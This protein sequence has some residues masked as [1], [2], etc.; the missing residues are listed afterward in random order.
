MLRA[1]GT[2][3][4]AVAG[5]R[6]GKRQLSAS[7]DLSKQLEDQLQG[8]ATSE[9]LL[10]QVSGHFLLVRQCSNCIPILPFIPSVYVNIDYSPQ[11]IGSCSLEKSGDDVYTMVA[12]DVDNV[13][14]VMSGY[15]WTSVGTVTTS[16]FVTYLLPE[17]YGGVLNDVAINLGD[18]DAIITTTLTG[19]ERY[20][21]KNDNTTRY[22]YQIPQSL[23][24]DKLL[25]GEPSAPVYYQ[26]CKIMTDHGV[27]F[28]GRHSGYVSFGVAGAMPRDSQQK[29]GG[30]VITDASSQT[31]ISDPATAGSALRQ[32]SA[33][34]QQL[35]SD[36]SV[37]QSSQVKELNSY[38]NFM[39]EH[40]NPEGERVSAGDWVN[41]VAVALNGVATLVQQC[42]DGCDSS[43]WVNTVG[44]TL[45]AVAFVVG[46]AFPPAGVAVAVVGAVMQIVSIFLDNEGPSGPPTPFSQ[47]PTLSLSQIQDAVDKS[48][49][50]YSTGVDISQFHGMSTFATLDVDQTAR[51][52]SE[53]SHIRSTKGDAAQGLI[54]TQIQRWHEV[55]LATWSSYQTSIYQVFT[56]YDDKMGVGANSLRKNLKTWM[57]TC[58]DKCLLTQENPTLVIAGNREMSEC[59]DKTTDASGVFEQLKQLSSALMSLAFKLSTLQWSIVAIYQQATDCGGTNITEYSCPYKHMV[60]SIDNK[61][62]KVNQYAFYVKEALEMMKNDCGHV[63]WP[64]SQRC[65]REKDF[66][67]YGNVIIIPPQTVDATINQVASN[68]LLTYLGA[69][70]DMLYDGHRCQYYYDR[71]HG[72]NGYGELGVYGIRFPPYPYP[73]GKLLYARYGACD[74]L[75]DQVIR[76]NPFMMPQGRANIYGVPSFCIQDKTCKNEISYDQVWGFSLDR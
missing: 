26:Q 13:M 28:K 63:A 3:R 22:E 30:V 39:K 53:L 7:D 48:I 49:S 34:L 47:I 40:F 24:L 14:Y 15:P 33:D 35:S 50:S 2:R 67:N 73:D 9:K 61:V 10:M 37:V 66:C 74:W 45:T 68:G 62:S 38:G 71:W 59:H 42:A 8:V 36:A 65:N 58:E 46:A 52:I 18:G 11:V 6:S 31:I 16:Y 1:H 75:E 41:G 64:F 60:E 76:N 29:N 5:K 23:E 54:D 32:S 69:Y 72:Q 12:H 44:M 57:S 70:P 20:F 4:T 25:G 19:A 56:S 27:R 55:W 17:E 43:T 21:D 51:F